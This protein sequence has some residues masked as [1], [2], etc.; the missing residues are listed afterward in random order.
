MGIDNAN[1]VD[2]LGIDPDTGHA[3][4]VISDDMDWSDPVA[5]INALQAKIGAYIG[6]VN[7]GQLEV[8]LPESAG[9][10]RKM[11][12]IQQ[13]EPPL[14]MVPILNQLGEQLEAFDIEFGYGP[15]PDGYETQT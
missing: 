10:T 11:A 13:F 8:A 4:L 5:H 2:A 15:L 6:F 7:T 12:V 3:L 9:R 14:Q 1:A